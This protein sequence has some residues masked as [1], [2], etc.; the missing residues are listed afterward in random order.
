M[1]IKANRTNGKVLERQV[2]DNKAL[3]YFLYVPTQGGKNAPVLVSVHGIS[4]NADKHARRFSRYAERHGVVIVAPLFDEQHYPGYQRLGLS[5]AR[6]DLALNQILAEVAELTQANTHQLYMFG[7]S[8]G[9][10]FVHRYAMA[11]PNRVAAIAI[12]AAGWYTLPDPDQRF[13]YGIAAHHKLPDLSFDLSQF[14][15]IPAYAFV[16]EQDI[17]RDDA[18]RQSAR[19]DRQQGKTRFERAERWVKAMKKAARQQGLETEFHFMPLP[20]AD[21]S[22][23]RSIKAGGMAEHVFSCLFGQSAATPKRRSLHTKLSFT[24]VAHFS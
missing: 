17:L 16:G 8:G 18:L 14:L 15:R 13:P 1:D 11:Y 21:H 9:G 20:K 6:A 23:T 10:Q 5:G 19:L 22:F 2:G 3:S 4:R 12:G 7:Y 24:S